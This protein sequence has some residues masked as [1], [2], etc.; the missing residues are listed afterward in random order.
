VVL[1]AGAVGVVPGCPVVA[2]AVSVTVTVAVD[3]APAPLL[4]LL[5]QAASSPAAPT[6][7]ATIPTCRMFIATDLCISIP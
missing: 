4:G 1:V 6:A 7:A 5:P 2:G 3:G